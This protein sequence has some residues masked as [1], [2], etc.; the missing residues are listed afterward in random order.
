MSAQTCLSFDSHNHLNVPIFIQQ[1]NKR[2]TAVSYLF[3]YIRWQIIWHSHNNKTPVY[4]YTKKDV[5][6]KR[7]DV[8]QEF[9]LWM[10]CFFF[11]IAVCLLSQHI[12]KKK[13]STHNRKWIKTAKYIVV[14]SNVHSIPSICHQ[15]IDKI[16]FVYFL[17][18]KLFKCGSQ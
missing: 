11:W 13:V 2:A 3:F 12:I 14:F 15:V 8:I 5:Q 7:K 16:H 4:Q 9:W 18:L 1:F 6:N 10:S 17:F